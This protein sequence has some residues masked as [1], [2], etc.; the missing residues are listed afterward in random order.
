MRR[1]S[2]G[3]PA[4]GSPALS[5]SPLGARWL[6]HERFAKLIIEVAD[7]HAAVSLLEKAIPQK[8]H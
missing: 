8:G 5:A 7:P 3:I 4:W 1:R 2:A 6:D